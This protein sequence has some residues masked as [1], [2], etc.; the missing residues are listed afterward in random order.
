VVL[1]YAERLL[2]MINNVMAFKHFREM[3]VPSSE[4]L[5]STQE[6]SLD[7]RVSKMSDDRKMIDY[8]SGSFP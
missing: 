4:S 7:G 5:P 1:E 8:R 3:S 2:S 6:I